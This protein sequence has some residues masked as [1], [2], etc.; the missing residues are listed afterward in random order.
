MFTLNGWK[1]AISQGSRVYTVPSAPGKSGSP[2]SRSPKWSLVPRF[3]IRVYPGNHWGDPLVDMIHQ[4][5]LRKRP[6]FLSSIS[7][8][9]TPHRSKDGFMILE[10]AT[11]LHFELPRPVGVFVRYT[12]ETD[13]IGAPVLLHRMFHL[14]RTLLACIEN[15]RPWS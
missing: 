15:G 5:L 13:C 9:H 4:P 10:S 8:M 7:T 11:P 1:G 3:S 14:E 12:L 2:G 6:R